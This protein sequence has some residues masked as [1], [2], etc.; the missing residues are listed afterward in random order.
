MGWWKPSRGSARGRSTRSFGGVRGCG[1]VERMGV[2]HS[3]A[4]RS[5]DSESVRVPK[6]QSRSG[7]GMLGRGRWSG[8]RLGAAAGVS[9]VLQCQHGCG[10]RKGK[11]GRTNVCTVE[12]DAQG[13]I[14][15]RFLM[16]VGKS[17]DVGGAMSGQLR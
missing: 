3:F 10:A 1:V 12:E 11:K 16:K 13:K 4:R 14:A 15:E 7:D 2:L 9:G 6:V 17:G 5:D 8:G